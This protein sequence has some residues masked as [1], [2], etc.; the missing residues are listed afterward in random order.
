[1]SEQEWAELRDANIVDD[2]NFREQDRLVR[3]MT[4]EEDMDNSKEERERA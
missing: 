3:A 1:M 4:I 2:E